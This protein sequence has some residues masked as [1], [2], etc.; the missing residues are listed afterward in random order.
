M[1]ADWIAKAVAFVGLVC[2]GLGLPL[3]AQQPTQGS[4]PSADW[5]ER[6]AGEIRCFPAHEFL[7][8]RFNAS[9]PVPYYAEAESWRRSAA[10]VREFL[11]ANF[12]TNQLVAMLRHDNPRVR[13]LALAALFD[14]QEPH[15]IP[16][17]Y[18]LLDDTNRTFDCYIPAPPEPDAG[19]KSGVSPPIRE[20]T[21]R[22]VASRF[23]SLYVPQVWRLHLERFPN[24]LH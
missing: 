18:A 19:F 16:H 20:Q 8:D 7:Y 15:L 6:L 5:V 23:L 22:L 4:L 13:T 9:D 17:F 14:R 24:L 11:D 21:V 1:S 12:S 2:I 3:R 10:L